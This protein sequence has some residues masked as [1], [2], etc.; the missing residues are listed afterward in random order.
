VD[1]IERAAPTRDVVDRVQRF[2]HQALT[3]LTAAAGNESLCTLSRD[4]SPRPAAKY[5]EGAA[6]ALAQAR[7]ALGSLDP[8]ED[9]TP[10]VGA[11][12]DRWVRDAGAG[13]TTSSWRAYFDGG[14]DSLHTL[15]TTPAE[16]TD[17]QPTRIPDASALVPD[18][19]SLAGQ[20]TSEPAAERPAARWS[21]RR[22]VATV[23]LATVLFAVLVASGGGWAPEAPVWTALVVLASVAGGAVLASYLPTT[24]RAWRP[25]LG[26]SPCAAMA[27]LTIVAAALFLGTDPHQASMAALA[28]GVTGFGLLQRL[29][30]AGPN[31]AV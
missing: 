9:A 31:C 5:H 3:S 18:L 20:G 16:S 21:R 15:L 24:G 23:A 13:A 22:S 7:R 26:C 10:T 27:A 6:A 19:V 30:Q 17:T 1:L 28:L 11:L 12:R 14:L 25:D 4:G 29:L 8:D 2:E